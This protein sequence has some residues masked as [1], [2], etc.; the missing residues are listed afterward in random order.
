[1]YHLVTE[2][3]CPLTLGLKYARAVLSVMI[4]FLNV[5]DVLDLDLAVSIFLLLSVIQ[6]S[7]TLRI[8][9]FSSEF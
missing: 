1:M 4:L 2:V 5:D 9:E 8:S 3:A 7:Y 6:S